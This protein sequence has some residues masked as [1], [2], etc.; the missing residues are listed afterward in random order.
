MRRVLLIVA[1]VLAATLTR[2]P[3]LPRRRDGCSSSRTA[4]PR[5]G[6]PSAKTPRAVAERTGGRLAGHQIPDR[7]RHAAPGARAEHARAR[8]PAAR[9]PGRRLGHRRAPRDQA[10]RAD[11]P[12]VRAADPRL[13][14]R[15]DVRVVGGQGELPRRMG[16][17]RGP[18]RPRRRDR[19]RRRRQPPGLRRP[20]RLRRQPGQQPGRRPG[21]HGPGRPRHPRRVAGVRR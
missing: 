1:T 18:Q 5:P 21:R 15:H 16:H 20:H 6:D 14:A 17:Q 9:R 12:G 2:W 13:A 8:P 11:R 19:H 10:V 3:T 7:A 4:P